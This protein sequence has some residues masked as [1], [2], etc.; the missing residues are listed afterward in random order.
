MKFP[1]TL[2]RSTFLKLSQWMAYLC[3][4][5][6]P[7]SNAFFNWGLYLMLI[8]YFISFDFLKEWRRLAQSSLVIL[9]LVLFSF[10]TF[11]TVFSEAAFNY[12]WFDFKHYVKLLGIIPLVLMFKHLK[13]CRYLFISLL[14][15]VG[16]LMMPTLLDGFGINKFIKLSDYIRASAAYGPGDLTYWRMHIQHGFHVVILFSSLML[17]ALYYPKYRIWFLL[18]ALMCMLDILFFIDARMALLS[19]IIVSVF[20]LYFYMKSIK[21]FLALILLASLILGSIFMSAHS[22]DERLS[23][24][25]TET[26]LYFVK[27]NKDTSGGNRLHFWKKSLEQFLKAPIFGNGSGSFKDDM[28]K[29]GDPILTPDSPYSHAHNEYITQLSHYGISG[30]FLFLSMIF[31]ALKQSIQI[32]DPWFSKTMFLSTLI[33]SINAITDS[34]LHNPWEGWTFVLILSLISIASKIKA[35]GSTSSR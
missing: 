16:V 19:L 33:F 3:A 6:M 20:I 14:A 1:E 26:Q 21:F 30:L 17:A 15:G 35:S 25:Y 34:S 12:A 7:W 24:I 23:S 22:T 8:F 9:S 11:K 29:H 28:I 18:G 5:G 2:N 31:M 27:Q 32:K 13:E 4:F 10:I